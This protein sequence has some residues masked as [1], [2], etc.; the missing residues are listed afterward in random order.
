MDCGANAGRPQHQG[1]IWETDRSVTRY[2][3]HWHRRSDAESYKHKS[4]EQVL[5][6]Q[7]TEKK[8]IYKKACEER[9]CHFTPFVA[10]TDGALGWEARSFIRRLG[11]EL[12]IKWHRDYSQVIGLVRT[13]LSFAILRAT[14]LCIRGSR[15]P[16]MGTRCL[17]EDGA[18]LSLHMW[19]WTSHEY[20][21]KRKT[22]HR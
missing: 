2:S 19:L 4:L 15:R 16:L 1:V 20:S 17:L 5:K 11:R 14:V 3:C 18:G 10:S 13:R 9:R 7:E 12:A 21:K 22:I 8:R 6:Q